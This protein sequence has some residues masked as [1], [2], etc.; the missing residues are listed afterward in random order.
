MPAPPALPAHR[1]VLI[2]CRQSPDPLKPHLAKSVKPAIPFRP[3]RLG[4]PRAGDT[5]LPMPPRS[6][7][8]VRAAS[9]ANVSGV[10][11]LM[12]SMNSSLLSV[13]TEL[14]F[15]SPWLEVCLN[16]AVYI[17]S[18]SHNILQSSPF[19]LL[20]QCTFVFSQSRYS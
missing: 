1:L 17:F 5:D 18:N 15:P 12:Y 9:T 16:P 20:L 10:S 7:S 8:P 2:M 13:R 11:Y 19:S 6:S 3:A 14:V 4:E